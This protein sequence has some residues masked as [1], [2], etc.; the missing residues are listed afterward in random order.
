M[1][2]VFVVQTHEKDRN[3]V[4][5]FLN[6]AGH[7]VHSYNTDPMSLMWVAR[8]MMFVNK[9]SVLVT[10]Q[11]DICDHPYISNMLHTVAFHL[12][13]PTLTIVY[14]RAAAH[15]EHIQGVVHYLAS[16]SS[17]PN[18]QLKIVPKD[19]DDTRPTELGLILY[20]ID[21]FD[22]SLTVK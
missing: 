7:D 5:A 16:L 10:S 6:A 2:K 12:P 8:E 19:T 14:T 18:H 15:Q 3:A 13:K 11:R 9:P 4:A 1:V 22:R 20:H 17:T 21:D